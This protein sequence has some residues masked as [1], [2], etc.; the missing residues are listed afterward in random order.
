LENPIRKKQARTIRLFRKIHRW[1]AISLFVFFFIISISGLVLGWK[2]HSSGIILPKTYSGTSSNFDEWLPLDS[3]NK[4]ANQALLA[5]T[6]EQ[7]SLELDRLDIRKEKGVAKFVYAQHYWG[8]QVDGA[9][10]AILHIGKRNS[11]LFENIHDGSILDRIF[12]SSNGQ[13]KLVYTT[14]MGLALMTFTITGF[15]LWYGPKRMQ[16]LSRRKP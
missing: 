5:F 9:T 6:N 4:I 12:G 8:V 2:K 15:W 3:L 1:S 11:D 7:L 14:L 13:I 16:R 10:G